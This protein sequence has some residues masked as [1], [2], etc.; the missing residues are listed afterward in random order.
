[1]SVFNNWLE[2]FI[3]AMLKMEEKCGKFRCLYTIFKVLI[4]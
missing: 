4:S 3:Y 2:L 1:M